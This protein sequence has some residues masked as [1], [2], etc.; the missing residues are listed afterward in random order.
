MGRSS[1]EVKDLRDQ[2]ELREQGRVTLINSLIKIARASTRHEA[3]TIAEETLLLAGVPLNASEAIP[4]EFGWR[5]GEYRADYS[6]PT[7]DELALTDEVEALFKRSKEI[8]S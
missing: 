3:V 1:D 8:K 4:S 5:V 7:P 6:S 2:I